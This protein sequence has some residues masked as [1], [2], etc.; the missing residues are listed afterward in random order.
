MEHQFWHQKWQK[1]EIGFHE[2]QGS[3][4]LVKHASILTAGVSPRIFVP[5]CGKSRDLSWLLDQ[6]C[7]VVGC[8]LNEKAVE[9]LFEELD[10]TPEVQATFGLKRFRHQDLVVFAGDIFELTQEALGPVTGIFDRAALVALPDDMRQ[11]Y[12]QHLVDITDNATQLLITFAYDQ[13]QMDGPPFS[14]AP[15]EVERL[16]AHTYDVSLLERTPTVG[17]LKKK[18]DADDLVFHLATR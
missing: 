10:V 4:L 16:Y 5:L 7:A 18:V 8:E 12:S 3:A 11:R 15:D 17:G 1:N 14:I 2:P 6:G 13:Q 9:Q